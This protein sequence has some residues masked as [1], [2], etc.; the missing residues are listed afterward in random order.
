MKK[1]RCIPASALDWNLYHSTTSRAEACHNL[2]L[3][4]F[5]F[6]PVARSLA[7]SVNFLPHP[8]V[9]NFVT[10]FQLPN[11]SHSLRLEHNV[12]LACHSQLLTFP[13][14]SGADPYS[15]ISFHFDS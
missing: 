5:P 6:D 12:V 1:S 13:E 7:H 15:F 14:T 2:P 8:R 3:S 9:D 11:V 10:G 4:P